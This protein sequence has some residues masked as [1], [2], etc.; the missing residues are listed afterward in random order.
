MLRE[1]ESRP[2]IEKH[3]V[4]EVKDTS[5]KRFHY[6]LAISWLFFCVG[7]VAFCYLV[8]A[9]P[10]QLPQ[11]E[12]VKEFTSVFEPYIFC[13]C[14]QFGLMILLMVPA[15]RLMKGWKFTALVLCSIYPLAIDPELLCVSGCLVNLFP[16]VK[17]GPLDAIAKHTTWEV[18]AMCLVVAWVSV[19]AT[20]KLAFKRVLHKEKEAASS[21][22]GSARVSD[23]DAELRF[24]S[25]ERKLV[26]AVP[27]VFIFYYPLLVF[28]VVR[29]YL[30]LVKSES[31]GKSA[32]YSRVLVETAFSCLGALRFTLL[33][34]FFLLI[35]K[36]ME[37]PFLSIWT[38]SIYMYLFLKAYH[39]FILSTV[40]LVGL[41][42]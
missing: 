32:L 23:T 15:G 26:M 35:S 25:F 12:H 29:S 11:D 33:H 9:I 8:L 41:I 28:M 16:S 14:I 19:P 42:N 5:L 3:K 27:F 17:F 34:T 7:H 21:F 1:I 13:S 2:L 38:L 20:F 10:R 39:S 37:G 24:K 22:E 40:R 36:N 4:D 6:R 30:D 31:F 18:R